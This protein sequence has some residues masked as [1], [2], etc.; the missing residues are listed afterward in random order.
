MPPLTIR[1]LRDL[2]RYRVKL[3]N[4][5]SSEK[6]RTQN[7]LTVSNIQLA[8]VLSDTFGK[9]FMV[10]IERL[11]QTPLDTH[12]DV[13]PFIHGSLLAKAVDLQLAIDGLITPEQAQKLT[14]IRQHYDILELCKIN[15]E[16]I[17]L[18]LADQFQKEINLIAI[19]SEIGVDMSVFPTAKHLC[20]WSGLTPQNNESAGKKKI[21]RISR[22]GVYIK[23][24]LVQCANAVVTSENI[25][26]FAIAIYQLNAVGGINGLL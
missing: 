2:M 21:V 7:C 17:I 14:I 18:S 15:L 16:S 13:T 8:N 3:T 1:Q 5:K 23:P 22:A 26:K 19:I 9:S 25:L 20:S 11:L 6:N 12:F 10:I 4:F 24:L